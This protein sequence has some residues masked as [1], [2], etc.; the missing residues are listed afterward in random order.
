MPFSHRCCHAVT[1]ALLAAV[2]A[3]STAAIAA[4]PAAAEDVKAYALQLCLQQNYE[5]SGRLEPDQL[6]DRSYLLTT[7]ALDNAKP[8]ATGRLQTF[9][10]QQTADYHR[11]EVPMKDEARRGPFTTIFA[12]CMA[13]Y[14][15]P[16]LRD[17]VAKQR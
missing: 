5:R 15:S 2:S 14:R 9:V 3:V 6:R 13:F 16:A 12:Q 1:A 8:G 10:A 7:Y 11:G 17:F 4:T